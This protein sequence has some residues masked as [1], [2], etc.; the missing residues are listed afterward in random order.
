MTDGT[1]TLTLEW[2]SGDDHLVAAYRIE[3]RATR[4][5]LVFDRIF[6]TLPQGGRVIEAGRAYVRINEEGLLVIEKLI[7]PLPADRDVESPEVPYARLLEPGAALLGEA[8][9]T[10]PVLTTPAYGRPGSAVG[11]ARSRTAM[12]RIGYVGVEPET[13]GKSLMFGEETLWSLP[14][15]WAA[16]RQQVLTGPTIDIDVPMA[17]VA[18]QLTKP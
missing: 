9:L 1:V 16:P 12:F 3:N 6:A 18:Q 17:G 13:P 7:P 4:P 5:V 11:R 15:F 8:R 10:V 2:R 14:H